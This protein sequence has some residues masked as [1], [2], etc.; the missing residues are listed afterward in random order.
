MDGI[1][2]DEHN[3]R[4]YVIKVKNPDG[5]PFAGGYVNVAIEQYIDDVLNNNPT[6]AYF[7]EFTQVT[8]IAARQGV[9]KLDAKGEATVVLA[10]TKQNDS[11]KPIVWVD[12][13]NSSNHQSGKLEKGEPVSDQSKVAPTNFQ[14]SHVDSGA[15]G[16]KLAV[17]DLTDVARENYGPKQINV[18]DVKG[19]KLT[20]LNQSGKPFVPP[21][22]SND[23]N[24][25]NGSDKKSSCAS[26]LYYSEHWCKHHSCTCT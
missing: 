21:T 24:D 2:D 20:L 19:F 1:K 9:V 16:A 13:N 8:L 14:P 11:A 5:T 3:G 4:E 12:Q 25:P 15:N 10:S 6:N 17:I 22:L 7:K 26:Y 23:H 18:E